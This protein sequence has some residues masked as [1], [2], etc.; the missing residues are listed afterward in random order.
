[1]VFLFAIFTAVLKPVKAE[2]TCKGITIDRLF[3]PGHFGSI[4]NRQSG[5]L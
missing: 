4:E 5:N 3:V 2:M 1:M